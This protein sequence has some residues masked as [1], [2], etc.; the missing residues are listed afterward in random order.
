MSNSC[1]N[2]A[3]QQRCYNP[4]SSQ[5]VPRHKLRHDN[6]DAARHLMADDVGHTIDALRPS[7]W[8]S[9]GATDHDSGHHY[10][11]LRCSPAPGRDSGHRPCSGPCS[12]GLVF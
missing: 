12:A 10:S 4:G 1:H 11:A 3:N 7:P 6:N 9:F 8:P 2:R 5:G